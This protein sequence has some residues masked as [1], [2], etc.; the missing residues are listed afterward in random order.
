[1]T[2][3]VYVSPQPQ[4]LMALERHLRKSFFDHCAKYHWFDAR[5]TEL[6]SSE[7]KETLF[8]T[9]IVVMLCNFWVLQHY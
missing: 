2:V 3:A 8:R 6:Q 7:T 9:N 1:M 4:T 5:E